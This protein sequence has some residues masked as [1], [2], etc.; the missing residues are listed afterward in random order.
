VVHVVVTMQIRQGKVDEFLEAVR[1]LTP[2]VLQEPGCLAYDFTTDVASPLGIQEPVDDH[3]VTLIER[4]ESMAA[5]ET[6]ANPAGEQDQRRQ[7]LA[8]TMR[9][10]RTSVTARV[11]ESI[12]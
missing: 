10:L 9:E 4:W 6:H 7:E 8:K 11:T 1:E 3:R 12:A 2:Y 5:L